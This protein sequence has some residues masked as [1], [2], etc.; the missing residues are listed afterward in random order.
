MAQLYNYLGSFDRGTA[1]T[2]AIILFGWVTPLLDKP[3]AASKGCCC[4]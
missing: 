4:C 1:G 2:A 3:K